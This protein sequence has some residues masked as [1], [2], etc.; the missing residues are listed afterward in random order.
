MREGEKKTI[1][2][3][4]GMMKIFEVAIV[5]SRDLEGSGYS[6]NVLGSD[7]AFS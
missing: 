3:I 2:R 6:P 1:P 4:S 5:D 7:A